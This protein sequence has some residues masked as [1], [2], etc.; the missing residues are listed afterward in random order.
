MK[1]K[2]H[3][4]QQIVKLLRAAEAK[5]AAGE[6][7]VEVSRQLGISDTTYYSWRRQY[8]QMKLNQIKQLKAVQKENG[9]LKKLVADLSLDKAILKEALSGNY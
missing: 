8:G 4:P 6:N 5:L 9:R 2:Y 1:R 3:R 7:V